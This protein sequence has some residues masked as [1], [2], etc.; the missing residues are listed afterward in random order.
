MTVTNKMSFLMPFIVTSYLTNYDINTLTFGYGPLPI[1]QLSFHASKDDTDFGRIGLLAMENSNSVLN[2]GE[3]VP[4]SPFEETSGIMPLIDI[5]TLEASCQVNFNEALVEVDNL[6][7]SGDKLNFQKGHINIE[8]MSVTGVQTL[9]IEAHDNPASVSIGSMS[10][11]NCNADISVFDEAQVSVGKIASLK[12]TNSAVQLTVQTGGKFFADNETEMVFQ[13][14]LTYSV[15]MSDFDRE[16]C[17]GFWGDYLHDESCCM[18]KEMDRIG[19]HYVSGRE[20]LKVD[21]EEVNK[22]NRPCGIED[23]YAPGY[24]SD[25]DAWQGQTYYSL[26]Q[27]LSYKIDLQN[28]Q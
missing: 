8:N 18:P 1:N 25:K 23:W 7:F 24:P 17:I 9:N 19:D 10:L 2:F 4:D 5:G 15:Y 27:C 6:K 22:Y 3:S 14:K 26:N 12:A 28:S 11:D 20:I 13:P 16:T 21:Y